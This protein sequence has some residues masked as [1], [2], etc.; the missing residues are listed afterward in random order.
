MQKATPVKCRLSI[1]M[2]AHLFLQSAYVY[3][4]L[5]FTLMFRI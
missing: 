3:G 1:K 5:W 4:V 2:P